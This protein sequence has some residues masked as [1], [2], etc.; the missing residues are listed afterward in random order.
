MMLKGKLKRLILPLAQISSYFA[1]RR[2]LS[3]LRSKPADNIFLVTCGPS[4]ALLANDPQLKQILKDNFVICMK[5]AYNTFIEQT[6]I[7][8]VN[9]IRYE[10]Y[11]Y[12][13]N[14]PIILSVGKKTEDMES[15]A[16]FPIAEFDYSSAVFVTN[17]YD[18]A[19]LNRMG[20]VRPWG[21]GVMYELG[22]FLPE[23][24]QCKK[25]VI[26]GFD[27]NKD[28]KYHF[29]DDH[30]SQDSQSYSVDREE[31]FYNQ[32]TIPHLEKWLKSLEIDV[33]LFSPLSA[34]PFSNKITDIKKLQ[35]FLEE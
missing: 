6:D 30:E 18:G 3:L 35:K 9:D 4:L 34:L 21:I 1:V 14:R 22:L 25:L 8:V 19:S 20:F 5:Q 16:H 17:D 28:G 24:L 33:A 32:K 29:Y 11:N 7:H 27:M 12:E 26:I 10:K 2:T 31:F 23:I 15:D 13:Q